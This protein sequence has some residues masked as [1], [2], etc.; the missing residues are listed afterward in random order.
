MNKNYIEFSSYSVIMTDSKKILVNVIGS[1]RL[2]AP[3]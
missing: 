3:E 1:F 2:P